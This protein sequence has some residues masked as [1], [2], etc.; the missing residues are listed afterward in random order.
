MNDLVRSII[1]DNLKN[2]NS[3]IK[4]GQRIIE[5]CTLLLN[6]YNLDYSDVDAAFVWLEH[7]NLNPIEILNKL[8]T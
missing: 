6:T 5:M 2:A 4:K 7:S 8:L 3:F 1:N